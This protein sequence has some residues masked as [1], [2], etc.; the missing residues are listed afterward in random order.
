MVLIDRQSFRNKLIEIH[1]QN[2]SDKGGKESSEN[3]QN[4]DHFGIAVSD[5]K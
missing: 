2:C 5:K 3:N 1:T 4:S